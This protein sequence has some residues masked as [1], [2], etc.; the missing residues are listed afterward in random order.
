MIQRNAFLPMMLLLLFGYTTR[1]AE[2]KTAKLT[3]TMEIY[4][5]RPDPSF[6]LNVH[7]TE[8]V[9]ERVKDLPV[10]KANTPNSRLGYRGFVLDNEGW[11]GLPQSIHVFKGVVTIAKDEVETCYQ[12]S[13]GLETYLLALAD[14]K[15]IGA[16][17]QTSPDQ[18]QQSGAKK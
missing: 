9:K 14:K 6:E 11:T 15:N 3:A 16:H 2:P 17:L 10:I 8:E 18:P 1:A 12:D 5:G 4:S 13:K 7:E